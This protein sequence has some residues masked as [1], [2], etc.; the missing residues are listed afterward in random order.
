MGMEDTFAKTISDLFTHSFFEFVI[1]IRLSKK[2]KE[3]KIFQESYDLIEDLLLNSIPPHLRLHI[4]DKIL[5]LLQISIKKG[6]ESESFDES[7]SSTELIDS[8][9]RRL[10]DKEFHCRS[11]LFADISIF[12]QSNLESELYLL[13]KVWPF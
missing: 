1:R 4:E 13:Q 2:P 6:N 9:Q 8:M 5:E 10:S 3:K 7:F 12:D 11:T